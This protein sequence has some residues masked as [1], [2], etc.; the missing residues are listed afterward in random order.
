MQPKEIFD[1]VCKLLDEWKL[2]STKADSPEDY[3]Y[4]VNEL[5]LAVTELQYELEELFYESSPVTEEELG[6]EEP[7]ECSSQSPSVSLLDSELPLTL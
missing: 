6:K 1:R 5:S 7:A 3:L 4:L 2:E